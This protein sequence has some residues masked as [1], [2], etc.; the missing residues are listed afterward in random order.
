MV[1]TIDLLPARQVVLN[2]VLGLNI[3]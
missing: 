2:K 1:T 3:K